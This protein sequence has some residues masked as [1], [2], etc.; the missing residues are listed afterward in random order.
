M[1]LKDERVAGQMRGRALPA[2]GPSMCCG[3]RSMGE[4]WHEP[5]GPWGMGQKGVE[6]QNRKGRPS[7]RG[8]GELG[9]L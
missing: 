1:V 7:L 2:E 6:G 3:E 8:S 9:R 4:R 5:L